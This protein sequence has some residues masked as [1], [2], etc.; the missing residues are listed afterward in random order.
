MKPKDE[1]AAAKQDARRS[2]AFV[3]RILEQGGG[4]AEHFSK[5]TKRSDVAQVPSTVLTVEYVD[6]SEGIDAALQAFD[7][8]LAKLKDLAG[9]LQETSAGL[10]YVINQQAKELGQFIESINHRLDRIFQR[11]SWDSVA[12]VSDSEVAPPL[13]AEEAAKQFEIP[14][15]FAEDPAHQKAWRTARVMA[16]D[17]E[18]Y[19]GD[20]V[21][22]GVLYD[23]FSE[24]LEEPIAEARR[25]YQQRV[26]AK[27]MDEFDYFALAIEELTTRK[28]SEIAQDATSE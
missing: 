20:K 9:G 6:G 8:R 15:Q 27:V 3:K 18:A 12:A 21:R 1:R 25:T 11:L 28:K 24:L 22:E 17:L 16:A 7:E 10:I 23:N 5:E 14:A 4:G 19:Y 26:S 13:S 2:P